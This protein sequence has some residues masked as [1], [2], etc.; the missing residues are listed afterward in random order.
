MRRTELHHPE[1]KCHSLSPDNTF[2]QPRNIKQHRA[3]GL[4][5]HTPFAS[6]L[7]QCRR[8]REDDPDIVWIVE[9]LSW[10]TEDALLRH[11]SLNKLEVGLEPWEPA[12]VYPDHH[13]HRP[14]GH[15]WHQAGDA[16]QLGEGQL[17]VVLNDVDCVVKE[18]L[19]RVAQDCW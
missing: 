3:I 14:L 16:P 2:E 12:P 7:E 17:G 19:W 1:I 18:G 10:Q 9:A 11:K 6:F 13:V 8:H 15:H 4:R 5:T